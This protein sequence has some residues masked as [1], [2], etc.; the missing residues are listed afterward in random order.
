MESRIPFAR[1]RQYVILRSILTS[2]VLTLFIPSYHVDRTDLTIRQ[3][4]IE[5]L[6]GDML[7]AKDISKAVGISEKEVHEHLPHIARSAASQVN[8][9]LAVEPSKCLECGFV[10]RKRTRLKTPSKCPVCRSEEITE[11][12]FGIVI[13][14]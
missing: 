12:R 14:D 5:A 8:G 4:I 6:R 13:K 10:F 7:T 1:F 2:D 9:E 3:R 11:T